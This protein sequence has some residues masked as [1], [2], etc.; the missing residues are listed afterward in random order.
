MSCCELVYI[1]SLECEHTIH[2]Q[3]RTQ[4]L[5]ISFKTKMTFYWTLTDIK[6]QQAA[7]DD[8]LTLRLIFTFLIFYHV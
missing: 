4:K 2:S 7:F 1:I 8:P 5:S 3:H 6:G